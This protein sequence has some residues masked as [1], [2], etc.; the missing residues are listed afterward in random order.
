MS[1]QDELRCAV[2]KLKW[3]DGISYKEIATELLDMNVNAFYNFVNG[4]CDLG[5]KRVRLLTSYLS[6]MME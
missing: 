6:E 1:K 5:Y 2:R 3:Q 4:Q